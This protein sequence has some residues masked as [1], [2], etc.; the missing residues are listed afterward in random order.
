MTATSKPAP[1]SPAAVLDAVVKLVAEGRHRM[2]QLVLLWHR[3][4]APF[5]EMAEAVTSATEM[6]VTPPGLTAQS[7]ID[8]IR[9]V[10]WPTW[11]EHQ[12]TNEVARIFA[13]QPVSG[14]SPVQL[15]AR[16]AA[17]MCID[18]SVETIDAGQRA[19][20]AESPENAETEG[21]GRGTPEPA[22]PRKSLI[23]LGLPDTIDLDHPE[24]A[25]Q[26]VD[27][28]PVLPPPPL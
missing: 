14:S 25:Q 19:A 18:V 20:Y 15:V 23:H 8:S 4:R 16:I 2:A 6:P 5:E 21:V 28:G 27:H 7:V 10:L 9:A 1:G 26:P 17:A 3:E 22:A 13:G 24:H 12:V 11:L